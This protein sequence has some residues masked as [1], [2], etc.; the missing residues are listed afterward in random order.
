MDRSSR[1]T[2][3]ITTSGGHSVVLLQYIVAADQREIT[4][5]YIRAGEKKDAQ[6]PA[7]KRPMFEAE[8]KSLEIVIRELDGSK[9]NIVG[10]IVN[11]L[12]TADY[13]EVINAVKEVISPKKK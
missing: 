1:P 10:R 9:E 6:A 12:P 8:D 7:D 2:T 13:D 4:E 5:I 3:T 11:E